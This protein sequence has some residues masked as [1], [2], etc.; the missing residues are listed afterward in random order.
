MGK[1]YLVGAGPGNPELLTVR[2]AR[3]LARADVVLHDALVSQEILEL[4]NESA[5]RIDVG[6]R[7]GVKLLI[8]DEIN[9]L[10]VDYAGRNEIVVRLKG[11]DPSLF[12]RAGEE[13]GALLAAGVDFEIVPGITAAMAGAAAAGISLTDR[14]HASSVL[15]VTAQLRPGSGGPNWKKLVATGA[16]LA[17]YMPGCNYH[18][19]ACQLCEAGLDDMTACAV[20]SAASRR[21]QQV[22]RTDLAALRAHAALPAPAIVIVGECAR[23]AEDM[24]AAVRAQ[25]FPLNAQ[26]SGYERS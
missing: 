7:K 12:G 10:L 2:A 22:L 13:I 20:V 19:L 21:E 25:V 14:R 16:T 8:Q 24:A 6:K 11:G 4:I 5:T 1:V 18:E 26:E 9:A 15:F 23:G 17:I 3:L